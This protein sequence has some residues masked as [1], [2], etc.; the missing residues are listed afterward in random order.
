MRRPCPRGVYGGRE[1]REGCLFSVGRRLGCRESGGSQVHVCRHPQHGEMHCRKSKCTHGLTRGN[2][3]VFMLQIH[4]HTC[5]YTVQLKIFAGQKLCPTQLPLPCRYTCISFFPM[6]T[7]TTHCGHALK[8]TD[9][10]RFCARK[11]T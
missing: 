1:G 4:V 5:I 8:F 6:H 7:S 10:I 9:I 3:Q 11:Y 2:L